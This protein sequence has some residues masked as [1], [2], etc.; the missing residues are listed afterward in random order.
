MPELGGTEFGF[1]YV[2]YHS[3]L[4]TINGVTGTL[5]GAMDAQAA[6]QS[7]LLWSYYVL[8]YPPGVSPEVDAAVAQLAS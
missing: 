7:T 4:P 5:Q 2:N 3:R 1:Y 6:G 8:G